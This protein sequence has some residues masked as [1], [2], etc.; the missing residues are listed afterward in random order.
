LTFLGLK[1]LGEMAVLQLDPLED[2]LSVFA[3]EQ[4]W[5]WRSARRRRVTPQPRR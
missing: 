5:V 2:F 4:A 3:A 1:P